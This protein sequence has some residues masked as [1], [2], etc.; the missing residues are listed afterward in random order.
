MANLVTLDDYKTYKKITKTDK[1][2]QLQ[3]IIDSV[4]TMVETYLGR[5]ILDYYATPLVEYHSPQRGWTSLH[6]REWPL[7]EVV[8]VQQREDYTQPYV[9]VD[10]VEYYTD[11]FIYSVERHNTRNTTNYWP[12]GSGAVKVTYKA[13]YSETPTDLRIAALDLVDHYSKE[14]FK[15]RKS[16]GTASV[17]TTTARREA[18]SSYSEWPVHIVRVLDLYR[19]V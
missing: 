13:G 15:E 7:V 3:F 14:E 4:N 9:V 19:Y 11:N 2:D 18:S 5:K 16:I 12:E 6:L 10:P 17:D 8:S 1:D